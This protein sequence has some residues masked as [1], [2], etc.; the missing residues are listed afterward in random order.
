MIDNKRVDKKS[1]GKSYKK[2]YYLG[3][4]FSIWVCEL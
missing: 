2:I 4:Q 1:F 3:Q